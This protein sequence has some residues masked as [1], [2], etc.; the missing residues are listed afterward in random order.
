MNTAV[1][2]SAPVPGRDARAS[3]LSLLV[4]RCMEAL[5]ESRMKT[6]ARELR[7]HEAF[8]EDLGRRQTHSPLF[9]M[10][11]NTLPFKV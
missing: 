10:Q 8:L 3:K 7:R 9:L 6:A 1:F 11:D 5:V 4:K 2:A